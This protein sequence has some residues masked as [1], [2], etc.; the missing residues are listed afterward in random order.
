MTRP[1]L[2]V[3]THRLGLATLAATGVLILFRGL[4][5]NMGAGLAVPPADRR[6]WCSSRSPTASSAASFWATPSPWP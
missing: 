2:A 6:P 3:A 5:T 4:V 1:A